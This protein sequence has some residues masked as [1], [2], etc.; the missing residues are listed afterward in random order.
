MDNEQMPDTLL[1][2]MFLASII[3]WL[4]GKITHIILRGTPHEIDVVKDALLKTK[5]FQ[6][7]IERDGASLDTVMELLAEK[8][9]AASEFQNTFSLPWPL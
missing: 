1:S 6:N 8:Q 4:N 7:E 9:A 3:S 2:K 5:A